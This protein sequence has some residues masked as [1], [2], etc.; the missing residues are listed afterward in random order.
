VGGHSQ[1]R[2]GAVIV[3]VP[4][5]FERLKERHRAERGPWHPNLSLRVHRALSWLNRA[6]QLAEQGDVDGQ[7]ILLWIAF[8]AAYATEI[9][10]KYRESEQ[11]TFR[12]FLEKL[13][14]LDAAKK[15]FD[16]MVWTEFPKSIRVL[17]DN[18]FVFAGEG[19]V[20]SRLTECQAVRPNA[21]TLTCRPVRR[22]AGNAQRAAGSSRTGRCPR[23][24]GRNTLRP[25]ITPLAPRWVVRTR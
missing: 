23:P 16:A 2:A 22:G 10:E 1:R 21:G 14:E 5:E 8:N 24:P 13:T 20:R 19:G 9:D 4:M 15:R 3:S 12:G 17:L 25:P 6:E 18:Q 11:Q 7:F